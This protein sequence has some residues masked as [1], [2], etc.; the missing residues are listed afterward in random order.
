MGTP[1][2]IWTE[3][4][5]PETFRVITAAIACGRHLQTHIDDA[6]EYHGLTWLSYLALLT[7]ARH[8]NMIHAAAIAR[9]IGVSRQTATGYLQRFDVRGML[10]WRDEPWIRSAWLTLEG[11]R[12]F[13]AATDD[14][15]DVIRAVERIGP[16]ERWAIIK[17]EPALALQLHRSFP[18]GDWPER[19]LRP[20]LWYG[21][22]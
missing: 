4:L 1:P 16:R 17:T 9:R 7:M 12:I 10:G 3:D 15:H 11:Q 21:P 14:L 18:G 20:P 19:L 6:L 22:P 13:D 8:G 5:P 2:S